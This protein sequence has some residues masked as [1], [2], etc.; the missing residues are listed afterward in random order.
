MSKLSAI[1]TDLIE[2]NHDI[3]MKKHFKSF[4]LNILS[5]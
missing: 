3:V 2:Q 5:T 1:A 4:Y